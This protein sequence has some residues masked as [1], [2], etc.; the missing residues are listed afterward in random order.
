[1][2]TRTYLLFLL[3][4]LSFST[5]P[6][7]AVSLPV[8]ANSGEPDPKTVQAALEQYR[9]LSPKQKKIK[10]KEARKEV[11]AFKKAKR[12]GLDPEANTLLLVI[13]A[14][15]LPPLAVYLHQGEINNKFWITLLLFLLGITAVFFLSWLALLA[16]IIYA[17]VVI[18]G[19]A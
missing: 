7:A 10:I 18:L 2:K 13:V 16:A 9:L 17:L 19:N 3:L 5:L 14:I 1:M 12:Q 15:F 11:K 8:V 6:A 4:F